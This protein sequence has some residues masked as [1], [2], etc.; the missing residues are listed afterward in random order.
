M[1]IKKHFLLKKKKN[2]KRKSG[3]SG[4]K[5]RKV[6]R[7]HTVLPGSRRLKKTETKLENWA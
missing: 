3:D 5:G 7:E 1:S 6:H 4:E 2:E